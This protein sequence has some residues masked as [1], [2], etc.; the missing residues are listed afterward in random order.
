MSTEPPARNAVQEIKM[1][2]GVQ[3]FEGAETVNT[4]FRKLQTVC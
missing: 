1:K 3:A 2:D 4:V